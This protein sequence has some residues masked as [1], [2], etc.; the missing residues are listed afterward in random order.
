MF[1][2]AAND[3]CYQGASCTA[4]QDADGEQNQ[5]LL[6]GIRQQQ[7]DESSLYDSPGQGRTQL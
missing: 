5:S 3:R 1:H 2:N 7:V 4:G 6:P